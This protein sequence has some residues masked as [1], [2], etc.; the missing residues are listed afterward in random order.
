MRFD[1]IVQTYLALSYIDTKWYELTIWWNTV[2][3]EQIG[4]EL[5]GDKG[6]SCSLNRD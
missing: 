6:Q 1:T 2:K 5:P 3:F 4:K